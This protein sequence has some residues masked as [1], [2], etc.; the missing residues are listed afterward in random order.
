MV[1]LAT[2]PRCLSIHWTYEGHCESFRAFQCQVLE[3]EMPS[4]TDGSLTQP[5]V[6]VQYRPL[7]ISEQHSSDDQVSDPHN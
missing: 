5:P 4:Q 6:L 7:H 2:F 3:I 1:E